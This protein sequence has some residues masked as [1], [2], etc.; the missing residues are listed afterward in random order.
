[1]A[2]ND[3]NRDEWLLRSV[4]YAG[5]KLVQAAFEQTQAQTHLT[6]TALCMLQ[7]SFNIL[8]RPLD[9]AIHLLGIPMGRR[10]AA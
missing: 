6:S 8:Q 7:L 3:A 10:Q 2:L 5:A 1:M 9:A 4:R